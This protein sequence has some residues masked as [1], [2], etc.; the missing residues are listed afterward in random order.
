MAWQQNL[1]NIES[2]TFG[3]LTGS[4]GES[5]FFGRAESAGFPCLS[6]VWRDMKCDGAVLSGNALYRI[7]IKSTSVP[8]GSFSFTHG[9]RSGT[10]INR[11]VDKT[12]RLSADDCD[13]A[14]GVDLNNGDCY[15][16]PIDILTIYGRENPT[17]NSVRIYREKWQLFIAGDDRLSEEEIKN[18]LLDYDLETIED[19]AARLQVEP[20]TETFTP[21]GTRGIHFNPAIPEERRQILIILIWQHL[22]NY[23]VEGQDL[24]E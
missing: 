23:L 6:K 5:L 18:G 16:I 24:N 15:I 11:S 4:A 3:S 19:I 20:P 10:Q 12:Q 22:A 7:E 14:V 21:E 1:T 8:D 13:F 2:G 9:R 17:R